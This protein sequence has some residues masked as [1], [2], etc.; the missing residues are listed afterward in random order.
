MGIKHGDV[1]TLE[2]GDRVKVSL[3]ILPKPITELIAGKKYRLKNYGSHCHT[4]KTDGTD[5]SGKIDALVFQYIGT[6]DSSSGKRHIFFV[7]ECTTY[8]MWS[9]ENLGFVVEEVK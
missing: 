4:K 9:T 1:I 3:E 7:K 2:N 5:Y 6:V 8:S